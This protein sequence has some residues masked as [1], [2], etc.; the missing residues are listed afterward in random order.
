MREAI[1]VGEGL[2]QNNIFNLLDEGNRDRCY[3]PFALLAETF[4]TNGV[5]LKT[6]DMASADAAFELHI[7][8]RPAIHTDRPKYLMLLET[9]LICPANAFLPVEYRKVFTWNDSIVDGLQNIK[10]NFPN[11]MVHPDVNGFIYRDR[12][13]CMIAGNKAPIQHDVRELYSE[14]VR[15]IRWFERN[16]PQDFDLYGIDWNLPAARPGLSGKLLRRVFR[17]L[18]SCLCL[19][20]FPSYRGKVERKMDVL[21]RTRFSICYENMRDMPGYITEKIFDCFCAG[22]VPVYWGANNIAHHVPPDC[23]IDRR[24][25]ADVSAVY[26][27]LKAM[28][29]PTY[30]GYQQRI[31][32]FLDSDAA[33][34]FSSEAFAETIV[35]TIVQDLGCVE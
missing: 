16:A 20:P 4:R 11:P 18:S 3:E 25:F 5:V 9:P 17:H 24:R 22:C 6:P 34:P 1:V 30:L 13:C 26:A 27:F 33:K 19:Q 28:D 12:V 29:Q 8:V 7:N 10:F 23:F 2:L 35:S 14:R 32:A 15:D 21:R 31:A